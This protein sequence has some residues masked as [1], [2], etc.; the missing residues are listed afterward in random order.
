MYC[1]GWARRGPSGIIGTNITDARSVVS[2]IVEDV[3]SETNTPC[4]IVERCLSIRVARHAFCRDDIPLA[5][6]ARILCCSTAQKAERE[7]THMESNCTGPDNKK[8]YF[9][10]ALECDMPAVGVRNLR[11]LLQT[12]I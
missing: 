6:F 7:T 2:A 8:K 10:T 1:S 3:R 11:D 4:I 5:A 12:R 9:K